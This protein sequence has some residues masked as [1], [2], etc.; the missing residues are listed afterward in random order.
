[1]NEPAC[2]VELAVNLLAGFLFGSHGEADGCLVWSGLIVSCRL[3]L[4]AREFQ[5]GFLWKFKAC[6]VL[7]Y[8]RAVDRAKA[9]QA[10][11]RCLGA[12]GAGWPRSRERLD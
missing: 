10:R 5:R 7:H 3:L 9:R 1:M 12:A 6:K 8:K 2:L 4:R 11:T